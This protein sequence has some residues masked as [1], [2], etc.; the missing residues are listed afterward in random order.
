MQTRGVPGYVGAGYG[1]RPRR[2]DPFHQNA[3]LRL[4]LLLFH[5]LMAMPHKPPATLVMIALNVL[6]FLRP[7][8]LDFVPTLREGCLTPSLIIWVRAAAFQR[9]HGRSVPW[10]GRRR[11]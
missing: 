11:A 7:E 3:I 9:P 5:Q 10:R 6:F 1:G 4:L 2:G 8:G